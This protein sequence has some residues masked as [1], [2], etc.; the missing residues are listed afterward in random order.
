M[1]PEYYAAEINSGANAMQDGEDPAVCF[2]QHA[3]A[4]IAA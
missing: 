4:G 2:G 1:S 3:N